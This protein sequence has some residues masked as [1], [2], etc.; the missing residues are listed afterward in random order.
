MAEKTA[1]TME[2]EAIFG[3]LGAYG[4]PISNEIVDFRLAVT[5]DGEKLTC[6]NAIQRVGTGDS[7]GVER[8]V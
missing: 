8:S 2:G 4:K 5:S 1:A 6:E 3:G 7:H